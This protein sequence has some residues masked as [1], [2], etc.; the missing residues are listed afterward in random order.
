M[1]HR[2]LSC[3]EGHVECFRCG[4]HAESDAALDSVDC[5]GPTT[6]HP[7]YLLADGT[8]ETCAAHPYSCQEG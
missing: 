7:P 5:T 8:R 2:R 3:D 6:E 1:F 4:A